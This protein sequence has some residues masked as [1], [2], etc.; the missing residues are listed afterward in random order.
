MEKGNPV[1]CWWDCKLVQP[2]GK[3]LWWFL[4]ELKIEPRYDPATPVFVKYLKEMK[5]LS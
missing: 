2:V 1:H 4:K 5:S 3:I